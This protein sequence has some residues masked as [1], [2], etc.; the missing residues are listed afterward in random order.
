MQPAF[1]LTDKIK[2]L[3]LILQTG[4]KS[5]NIS[6]VKYYKLCKAI[7][8]LDSRA[9]NRFIK[10]LEDVNFR[11][12]EAESPSK[13]AISLD[14]SKTVKLLL[15]KGANPNHIGQYIGE[16][17]LHVACQINSNLSCIQLLLD[18]GADVS[19]VDNVGRTI[20]HYVG[21]NENL[22]IVKT[23]MSLALENGINI[24]KTDEF[25]RTAL[26]D[27]C[28]EN[29][30]EFLKNGADI[31]I[32]NSDGD[33]QIYDCINDDI[34][35]ECLAFE[36]VLRLEYLGYKIINPYFKGS[37]ASED[38]LKLYCQESIKLENQ[39][40]AWN[41]KRTLYDLLFMH[42]DS[43][44]RYSANENLKAIHVE[45]NN[46][47]ELKYPYFGSVLNVQIRRGMRRKNV[48]Y[49]AEANLQKVFGVTPLDICRQ[50][51]FKYLDDR[52]LKKFANAKF[53]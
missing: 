19:A 10:C 24:N 12:I 33:Y 17:L 37:L 53:E 38:L 2:I 26:D 11:D 49:F 18:Y 1:R 23:V 30:V 41:P 16:T 27:V 14:Q 7:I 35:H 6:Q 31:N 8:T 13:F 36:Y 22:N 34:Q 46:D 51:I 20:L 3:D 9:T 43:L 15:E 32:L 44:V 50:K 4:L 47:L 45:C 40:I 25:G 29:V 5:K 28:C 21:C 42:R 48:T 52:T 39:V